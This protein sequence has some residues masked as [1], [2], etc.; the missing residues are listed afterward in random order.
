[1]AKLQVQI[2]LIAL[3]ALVALLAVPKAMPASAGFTPT[4]TS[5]PVA[6]T[7]TPQHATGK[8]QNAASSAIG[9]DMT[10]MPA[11]VPESAQD[12]PSPISTAVM[13]LVAL[14]GLMVIGPALRGRP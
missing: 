3:T 13:I 11:V 5:A 4:P 1:M 2:V 6:T 7:S 9:I 12:Q 8:P 10:A 14:M